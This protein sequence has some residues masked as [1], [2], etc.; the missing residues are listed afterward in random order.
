MSLG[1]LFAGT[2][3]ENVASFPATFNPPI[4]YFVANAAGTVTLKTPD[5]TTGQDMEVIAGGTYVGEITYINTAIA[6]VTVWR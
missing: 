5:Q 2:Y 6:S 1:K 4:R 3:V